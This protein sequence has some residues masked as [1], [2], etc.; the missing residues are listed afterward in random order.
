MNFNMSPTNEYDLQGNLTHELIQLYG[1]KTKIIKAEKRNKDVTVFGDYSHLMTLNESVEIYGLPEDPEGY[2]NLASSGFSGFGFMGI[3]SINIFYSKQSIQEAY[4]GID[5]LTDYSDIYGNLV[6][7][8]SGKIMEITE[9]SRETPGANNMFTSAST[10][11]AYKFSMKI[12]DVKLNS[13]LSEEIDVEENEST[14]ASLESYFDEITSDEALAVDTEAESE[15]I[16]KNVD[17]VF[18]RLG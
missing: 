15:G 16:I 1:V 13:E 10:K 9:I 7:L 12:H 18:G 5:N 4:P 14:Y 17:S 6:V 2:N 11:N 8:P 3:E